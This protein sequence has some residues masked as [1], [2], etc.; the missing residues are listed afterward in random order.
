MTQITI[1]PCPPCYK[2]S[3]RKIV[4]CLDLTERAK[5][6]QSYIESAA[7][8]LDEDIS[9]LR[10]QQLALDWIEVAHPYDDDI[11]CGLTTRTLAKRWGVGVGT[12]SRWRRQ[13]ETSGLIMT[14]TQGRRMFMK[15]GPRISEGLL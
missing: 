10:L 4:A 5:R 2:K 8:H 1:Q 3:V 12:V 7:R 11:W 13:W 9:Y 15:A 14:T 6:K